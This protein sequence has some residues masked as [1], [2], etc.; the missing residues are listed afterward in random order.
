MHRATLGRGRACCRNGA[1]CRGRACCR[2]IAV[3]LG[4]RRRAKVTGH[5]EQGE[6]V[7]RRSP[8]WVACLASCTPRRLFLTSLLTMRR[9]WKE[10][11]S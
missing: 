4:L 1:C 2:A 5:G 3:R 10:D 7:S 6:L 9:S 11:T 8:P